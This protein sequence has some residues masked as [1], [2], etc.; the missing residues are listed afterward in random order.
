MAISNRKGGPLGR[1]MLWSCACLTGIGATDHAQADP[2]SLS[3]AS[4]CGVSNIAQRIPAGYSPEEL[5]NLLDAGCDPLAPDRD[6]DT[7]VHAAAMARDPAYLELLL[8]RG[9]SPDVPNRISGRT[10]I[11]SAMLAE[12]HRQFDMLLAAGANVARADT[13]GNT[14]LH[15]AAQINEPRHVLA[16]LKAGAPPAARNAQGQSFQRYLFMTPVHLLNE[17]TW[18]SRRAVTTWLL[19]H[20]IALE[21]DT[22]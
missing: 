19:Q 8:A 2:P 12:R 16:L 18:R 7:A 10:P 11:M 14:P 22:P 3:A 13:T 5:Q 1:A 20:G 4:E 21:T 15:V 9:L 17:E 6:G